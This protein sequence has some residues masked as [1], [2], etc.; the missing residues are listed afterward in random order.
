M[1]AKESWVNNVNKDAFLPPEL[2]VV[3]EPEDD[4]APAGPR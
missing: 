1:R 4:T 3:E 2:A